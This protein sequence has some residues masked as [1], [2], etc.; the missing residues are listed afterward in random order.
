MRSADL[1]RGQLFLDFLECIGE[2]LFCKFGPELYFFRA[3]L[4]YQEFELAFPTVR[5][6]LRHSSIFQNND[7]FP[8]LF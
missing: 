8:R 3:L 5:F 4:N 1:R 6:Q 2:P 7:I